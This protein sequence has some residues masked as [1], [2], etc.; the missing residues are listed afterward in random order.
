MLDHEM[1]SVLGNRYYLPRK[2]RISQKYFMLKKQFAG[3]AFLATKISFM[4][5]SKKPNQLVSGLQGFRGSWKLNVTS[6]SF[7]AANN[8]KYAKLF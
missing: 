7:F 4:S 5:S 8:A 3:F 6:D 1:L 2:T